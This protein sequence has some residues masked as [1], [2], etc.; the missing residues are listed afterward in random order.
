MEGLC[1][2]G[3]WRCKS[4]F[5]LWKMDEEGD[6]ALFSVGSI[7]VADIQSIPIAREHSTGCLAQR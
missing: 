2:Y 7:P 4:K 3:V 5:N 1:N 6:L